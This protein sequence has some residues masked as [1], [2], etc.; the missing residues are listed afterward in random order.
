VPQRSIDGVA[1]L[2]VSCR[3][4]ARG[5]VPSATPAERATAD[6]VNELVA[7]GNLRPL[8]EALRNGDR[9]PEDARDALRLLA[10]LDVDRLV[11][12]ALD[13]LIVEYVEDPG[14]AHQPRRVSDDGGG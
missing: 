12:I 8:V 4:R 2:L 6:L 1:Y 5:N 9:G 13:T 10:D 14:L 7:S 11:Q 3:P